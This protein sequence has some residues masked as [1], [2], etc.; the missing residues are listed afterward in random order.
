MLPKKVRLQYVGRSLFQL[1]NWWAVTSL[2]SVDQPI[3][4]ASSIGLIG[5]P[6]R[7][8]RPQLRS[9]R[10]DRPGAVDRRI[11]M[12]IR[13]HLFRPEGIHSKT[14]SCQH[15]FRSHTS[16]YKLTFLSLRSYDLPSSLL[17]S[18]ALAYRLHKPW[19]QQVYP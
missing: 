4:A 3:G 9:D 16:Q 14:F 7:P 11:N 10:S 17:S 12:Y 18:Y 8:T 6:T 13:L 2:I 5:R 19:F 15:I 1:G